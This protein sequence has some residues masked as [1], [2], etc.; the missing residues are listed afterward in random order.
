MATCAQRFVSTFAFWIVLRRD[1]GPMEYGFAQPRM[2][3]I[4]HDNDAALAA[5]L[6]NRRHS[7]QGPERL[8]VPAGQ[9]TGRFGQQG[10]EGGFADARQRSENGSIAWRLCRRGSNLGYTQGRI[11]AAWPANGTLIFSSAV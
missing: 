10:G 1:A 11:G 9:R 8:V 3:G 2:G 4:T 6:G 7:R 5:A